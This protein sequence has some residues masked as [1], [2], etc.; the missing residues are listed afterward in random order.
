MMES[1]ELQG[2]CFQSRPLALRGWDTFVVDY[3]KGDE[4][5]SLLCAL[6]IPSE[7]MYVAHHNDFDTSFQM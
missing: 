4:C 3:T 7:L 5:L 1:S 2:E 6:E